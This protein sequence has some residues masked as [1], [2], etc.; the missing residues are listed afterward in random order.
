MSNTASYRERVGFNIRRGRA[1]RAIELIQQAED[2]GVRTV[3]MTMS[4]TG[5]DTPTLY[6]AA[7]IQTETIALGTSIVPAFTR[8]PI[9]LASQ[10]LV[11]DDLAP[12]RIRLGIGTSHAP[13]M[14]GRWGLPFDLPMARLREYLQVLRTALHT[15]E[16][17][18]S[19]D[20]YNVKTKISGAPGTPVLISAMRP[21]MFELAGELS[22]GGI[23]WLGPLDYIANVS[24]P[25]LERGAEQAGRACPPLITHVSVALT[26]DAEAARAAARKELAFYTR[27]PYYQNLFADAGYPLESGGEFGDALLDQLLLYGDDDAVSEQMVRLLDSGH[28]EL[29][30]MPVTVEDR[31]DEEMR[32]MN[33]IGNL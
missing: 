17:N 18:F 20:Y 25:A 23:S 12:G 5:S 28:D 6:A 10:A 15:G 1:S 14:V 9:A 33:L 30:A 7:A 32:L 16:V 29:L 4:S 2:A 27:L 24:R 8:Q 13:D 31:Y 11:L 3:W 26:T 22:D 19:G 21:R